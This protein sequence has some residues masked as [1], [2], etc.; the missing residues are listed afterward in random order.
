MFHLSDEIVVHNPWWL[1]GVPTRCKIMYLDI[2]DNYMMVKS[3]EDTTPGER[4]YSI[5]FNSI[6]Y[7]LNN[8]DSQES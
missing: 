5:G 7:E 2:K 4:Q 8:E 3:L 1:K 6:T